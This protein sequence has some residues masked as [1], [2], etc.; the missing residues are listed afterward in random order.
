MY[1]PIQNGGSLHSFIY[2]YHRVNGMLTTIF[3][4]WFGFPWGHPTVGSSHNGNAGSTDGGHVT[5]T[6]PPWPVPLRG[7]WP[8]VPGHI[9]QGDISYIQYIYMYINTHRIFCRDYLS[10]IYIDLKLGKMLSD[11]VFW[12]KLGRKRQKRRWKR[13]LVW[14]PE[15]W[16][17][18]CVFVPV[19]FSN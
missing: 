4:C 18:T 10:L 12:K 16:G 17:F 6:D 5:N 2:V 15:E 8:R 1:L 9:D 11:S 19:V 14:T 13:W 7:P 3:H